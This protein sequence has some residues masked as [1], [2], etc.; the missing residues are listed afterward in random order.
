M[1]RQINNE[2]R[3]E[4]DKV[5]AAYWDRVC[6]ELEDWNFKGRTDLVY[7]RVARLTWKERVGSANMGITDSSGNMVTDPEEVRETWKQYIESLYDKVGK[8]KKEDL[9]FEEE[10]EV[11][12]EEKGPTVLESEIL[13][14]IS[15]MQEGKAMEVDDI[16]AE[17][18]KSLGKKALREICGICQDINEEGKWP[19]AFTRATMIPIPKRNDAKNAV[20]LEQSVS[21][22]MHQRSC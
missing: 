1:Y 18:L 15:E 12:T 7:A 19:D 10:D 9:K 8:P 17:M 4:T 2:L 3:R 5:R 14:A 11:D 13:S 20:T 21:S 22:T 16:P 6:G